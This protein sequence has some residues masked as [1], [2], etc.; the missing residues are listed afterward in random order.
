MKTPHVEKALRYVREVVGGKRLA[1]QWVRLACQRHLDD[2]ARSKRKD[3]PYRF[4]IAKAERACRF[5]ELLPHVKGHWASPNSTGTGKI[6]LE[7]FQCFE[8]VSL[9]GWVEKATGFRRF[10]EAYI[11]RP[12]KNAK[13]TDAAIT[14]LYCLVADGEFGAE[15]YS[16]ATSEKQAWEVFRPAKQMVERTPEF[17]EAYGAQPNAKSITVLETGGRFEPIIGKP[18]DGSSP[19]CSITDEYHEHPDPTQ[20]DTMVTGMGARQ[21]PLALIITTAGENIDSPCYAKHQAAEKMLNSTL[22]NERLFAIIY[23]IDA[24]DD[25]TSPASIDKANPNVGVSVSREYLLDQLRKAVNDSREQNLYKTKHLNVWC[26]SRA[27]WMNMQWWDRQAD[28][29]LSPDQ[30]VGEQCV[31]TYDLSNRLDLVSNVRLFRRMIDE[32]AHYYF[33]GRHYAPEAAVQEPENRH[34]QGWA[35]DGHLIQTDGNDCDLDRILADAAEDRKLFQVLAAGFDPWNSI[36]LN[37]GLQK[38]GIK[39][40]EIPQQVQHFTEA[41][42]AVE[43]A[44][45]DGRFHHDGNPCMTWMVGNVTVKPDAKDNVFPRKDVPRNKIDGPV[46]MFMNMRLFMDTKGPSVYESRGLIAV[47]L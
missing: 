45:K 2:L 15:V 20:Y 21:Q 36:G 29:S 28:R 3:F 26:S 47:D 35:H 44:V 46:A 10:R 42:K 17:Q 38:L 33:F 40:V 8:R 37:G 19:S 32:Q 24:E 27:P 1:C 14:G 12:R 6:V 22:P 16:G 13:S 39:T 43:A 18:G 11:E 4:D 23:T 30:F 25:W 9:F 41:M 34:Y 5:A 7:P 31:L